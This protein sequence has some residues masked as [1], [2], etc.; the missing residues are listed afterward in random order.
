MARLEDSELKNG[1]KI[2]WNLGGLHFSQTQEVFSPIGPKANFLQ[3]S[4][5]HTCIQTYIAEITTSKLQLNV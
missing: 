4:D 2:S 5:T 1:V 3:V